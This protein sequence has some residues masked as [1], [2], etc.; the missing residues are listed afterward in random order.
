MVPTHGMP[1]YVD[2]KKHEG[3]GGGKD[4]EDERGGRGVGG[5]GSEQ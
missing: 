3:G 5:S 2:I 1:A 4:K